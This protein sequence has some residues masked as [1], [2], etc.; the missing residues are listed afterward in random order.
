M[1]SLRQKNFWIALLFFIFGSMT[2]VSGGRALFTESGIAT[3]GN[4]VPLVL[5][6]NFIAG[7][8]YLLAGFSTLKLKA[9]IRKLSIALATFN[10]CVFLYLLN[11]I[12]Q[13]GLYENRTLI[14]MS[15]RTAFWIG[16]AIYFHKSEMFKKLECHC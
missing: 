16:F 1:S 2:V 14:A 11:H 5:W 8:F 6:F 9:C 7:F 12:F 10:V 13:G 3:R 15:F 4:I